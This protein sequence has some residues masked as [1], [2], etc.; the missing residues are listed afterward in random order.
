MQVER[1]DGVTGSM[2]DREVM[3]INYR[4]DMIQFFKD[5]CQTLLKIG[6]YARACMLNRTNTE[7]FDVHQVAALTR[8]ES[9]VR[10]SFCSRCNFLS[11]SIWRDCSTA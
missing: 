7:H 9:L 2:V 4:L 11:S 10:I 6:V 3:T 5:G 8:S 1:P